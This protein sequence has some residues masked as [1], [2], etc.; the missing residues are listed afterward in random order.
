MVRLP[1][2]L[3]PRSSLFPSTTLFRSAWLARMV[4]GHVLL[5]IVERPRLCFGGGLL[6]AGVLR[7]RL[8]A[9]LG[10]ALHPGAVR[11]EEHTSELQSQSNPV[12]RLLLEK[13]DNH[14]LPAIW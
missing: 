11:S 7:H 12:C 4:L 6:R 5:V 10:R 8:E 13:K 2:R 9:S 3:H 14:T 1:L